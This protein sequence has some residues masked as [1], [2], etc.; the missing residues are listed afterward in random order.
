MDAMILAAGLGTR[1]GTIT[2]DVPKALLDLDGRSA[3]EHVARRLIDAGADRLIINVHHHADRIIEH[4]GSRRGFGVDVVFSREDGAPLETGGGLLHAS[5]HFR[6]DRPFFLHNVDVITDADLPALFAAHEQSGALATLAVHE[7]RTSRFL[8]FDAQR[9]LRGRLDTRTRTA[10]QAADPSTFGRPP[11]TSVEPL[12]RLAFAG[13]HVIAPQLLDRIEERGAF[14]IVDVYVRLAGAGER[15][16]AFDIGAA[17]WLEIGTP[18]RLEAARNV[19]RRRA[20][21]EG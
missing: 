20:E 8:L 5:Q 17:E 16:D 15:I 1:L 7:R 19:L 21:S 10:Q 14:S 12:L 11:A 9:R 4:V 3:L 2:Q 18:E 6:R 13:I